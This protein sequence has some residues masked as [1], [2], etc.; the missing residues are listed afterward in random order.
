MEDMERLGV[1]WEGAQ[2]RGK[3]RRK[4]KR[5][6]ANLGL[7]GRWALVGCVCTVY[8]AVKFVITIKNLVTCTC[9]G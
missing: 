2:C 7:P 9:V 3:W 4:I 6:P 1:C 5:H 8:T